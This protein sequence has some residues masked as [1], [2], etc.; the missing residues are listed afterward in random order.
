MKLRLSVLSLVLILPA[1]AEV[2][3][4]AIFADHMVLQREAPIPVWGWAAP[5]EEVSVAIDAE[6]AV[7]TK[8]DKLGKW[9]AVLAAHKA[10]GKPHTLT[11]KGKNILVYSDV[12]FGEVW[13]GSGQSNMEWAL[14]RA[15]DGSNEVRAASY[16]NIRLFSVRKATSPTPLDN[17]VGTWAACS[18]SN[19]GGFSAVLYFFGREVH[20][21]TRYPV[22]LIHSS[23][24]GTPAEA[25]M[26]L[27]GLVGDSN[28]RI[29]IDRYSNTVTSPIWRTNEPA[30]SLLYSNL[31]KEF[32]K[33]ARVQDPGNQGEAQGWQKPGFDDTA[34]KTLNLP[35]NW[36]QDATGTNV[37]GAFWYRRTI[38]IPAAWAGKDLTLQLGAVDDYDTT[39]FNGE[40]VGQTGPETANWWTVARKYDVAGK[41]VKA[42]AATIAVR[43]FDDFGKGGMGAKPGELVLAPKDASAS[44][45]SLE[46]GWRWK[47]EYGEAIKSTAMAPYDPKRP[48]LVPSFLWN[49]MIAPIVPF[50]VRGSVWYQGENNA[51]RAFQYRTLFPAMI[52]FWRAEWK[53]DLHFY[54]VQLANYMPRRELPGDSAWAELRE[55]QTMALSLTNSGMA[56]AIDIGQSNDI[57]PINKQEV[58]RRLA[59]NALAKVYGQKVAFSGPQFRSMKREGAKIRIAF[60]QIAGGLVV[61]NQDGSRELR[62]FAVAGED[63]AFQWAKAEIQKDHTV[64]VS[65]P[66][67]AAP[68]AVR[69]GWAD[70]P[71]VSLFNK[72]G[73]PAI[74]FRTDDWPGVTFLAR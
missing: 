66:G 12:L 27:D 33:T 16:S 53:Q 72:A 42:G 56:L 70:N 3:L 65:A 60:D 34:W 71:A 67:V 29:Y 73:L 47:V 36:F 55:A 61:S 69:Y 46:G 31:M 63:K 40:K 22:G 19:A 59:L 58:G 28:S 7:V 9:K 13:I 49:A 20:R 45:L 50:G 54:W 10:D 14:I 2:K 30:R 51:G 57:H 6:K 32:N 21:A 39:Y 26:G 25:W 48:Q 62:G 38:E 11:V 15:R 43:V 68:V 35:G 18:P 24:G 52:R 5:G 37:N 74:P 44:A 23:W 4:P 1:L 64:V 8:A 41:Y 17:V